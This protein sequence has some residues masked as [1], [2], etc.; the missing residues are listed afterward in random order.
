MNRILLVSTV[1]ILSLSCCLSEEY[2]VDLST[3]EKTLR[4]Y[5]DAYKRSDFKH[6]KRTMESS[7]ES[8][9]KERFDI[10][11]P[12]LQGY[13]ILK[14]REAKDRKQDTFHLPEGD[15]DALVKEIYKDNKESLNSFVLRKFG[16][17]WLIVD[18]LTI[19]DADILPDMNAIDEQAKKM[20]GQKRKK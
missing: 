2:E 3:P 20:L 8:I 16:N 11:K 4:A 9:G 10:V 1:L 15:V 5:Y 12:I 13:E 7:I 18:W 19:E 17:R 6:Q 14:T